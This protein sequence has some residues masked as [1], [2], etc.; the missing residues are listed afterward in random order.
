MRAFLSS[1]SCMSNTGVRTMV[2]SQP[3][4]A[5]GRVQR[6]AEAAARGSGDGESG[7]SLHRQVSF[8]APDDDGHLPE[9]IIVAGGA[10]EQRATTAT[11]DPDNYVENQGPPA[12]PPT[13]ASEEDGEEFLQLP[14]I[15]QDVEFTV[16]PASAH[17]LQPTAG[18][19][20]DGNPVYRGPIGTVGV[21]TRL[22]DAMGAVTVMTGH[23]QADGVT[24]VNPITGALQ[25][26]RGYLGDHRVIAT[27][28]GNGAGNMLLMVENPSTGE[29]TRG[30]EVLRG[31]SSISIGA[32]E[33]AH[34][35]AGA[36]AGAA[37]SD[38]ERGAPVV[39]ASAD[40]DRVESPVEVDEIES[41]VSTDDAGYFGDTEGDSPVRAHVAHPAPAPMEDVVPLADVDRVESPVAADSALA[42]A[43]IAA[44]AIGV[45][46]TSG[47]VSGGFGLIPA[48]AVLDDFGPVGGFVGG[49]APAIGVPLAHDYGAA[50]NHFGTRGFYIKLAVATL[51]F[52]GVV[53]YLSQTC[54]NIVAGLLGQSKD[55]PN[56][57]SDL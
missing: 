50:I 9:D 17:V 24:I 12:P 14:W 42:R 56:D 26:P 55:Q 15:A 13:P 6:G 22:D 45:V 47:G 7:A 5:P 43:S 30:P 46:A 11:V 4:D 20:A 51:L 1:L 2:S 29:L 52:A 8:S 32:D 31:V 28:G 53:Y 27:F 25:F 23:L 39:A 40:A 57:D 16:P 34:T 35:A 3:T 18:M 19:R 38:D 37:A 48:A 36:A 54:E 41:P 33:V 10:E 44:R 21:E 49:G